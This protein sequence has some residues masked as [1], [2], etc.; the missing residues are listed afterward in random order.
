MV[1]SRALSSRSQAST[2]HSSSLRGEVAA[3]KAEEEE[4]GEEED[5]DMEMESA[6]KQRAHTADRQ[7]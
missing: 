2:A 7:E 5:E 6:H 4:E 1:G 3:K